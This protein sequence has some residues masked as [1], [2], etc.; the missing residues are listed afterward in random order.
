MKTTSS[1]VV[2]LWSVFYLFEKDLP[3]FL[4]MY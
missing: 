4:V 1:E 3:A 2:F